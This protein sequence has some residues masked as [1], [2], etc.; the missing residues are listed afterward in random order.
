MYEMLIPSLAFL[1]VV[2][3]GGA[4]LVVRSARQ[5]TLHERIHGTSYGGYGGGGTAVA[6][7]AYS[8]ARLVRAME[9]V[10]RAV[11]T[12]QAPSGLREKLTQAGYVSINAPTI[13]VG[14]QLLLVVVALAIAAP[15]VLTL[16]LSLLIRG[17][18]A[19]FVV[20]VLALM[21]NLVVSAQQRK[22]RAEVQRHLPDAVDLL[23][24]CVSAGMGLDMA[25]NSV[26]EELRGVS[27][28][29]ADE[30]SL[31][32]LEMQLGATRA[33]ALRH[34]AERTGVDDISSLV[35][36][37]VQSEKFGTSVSQALRTYAE[38]MRTE[39]SQRAEE[40]AEKLM[41]KLLFPMLLFI[42]PVLFIVI[43]G[44]AGIQ[45]WAHFSH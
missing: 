7:S 14:A 4:V 41:V 45:L 17:C 28:T 32:T 24:I 18:I 35:A 29:V 37:L 1:A 44:P 3:V 38:S 6:S 27:Q 31:T 20:A 5:R 39:R 11:S 9:Q 43:L 13:Y 21:P 2:G 25:W 10:G 34:M 22:R 26:A 33:D 40:A 42:F 30:M 23:E 15:L 19:F 8:G 12:E 36:T 16:D